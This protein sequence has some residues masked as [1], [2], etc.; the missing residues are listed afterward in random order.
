MNK[1]FIRHKLSVGDIT[2]LS[3]QDSERIISA[4]ELREGDFVLL[5][6]LEGV[7]KGQIAYIDTASVEVEVFSESDREPES[8]GIEGQSLSIIQSVIPDGK[9]E[10]FIE[11]AVELGVNEIIPA[12][13]EYSLMSW[14]KARSKHNEWVAILKKAV[15]Q[16]RSKESPI[17]QHTNK[18]ETLEFNEL[19]EGELRLCLATENVRAM[20]L[21][22]VLKNNEFTKLIVAVGPEKGWHSEELE[23]F[24]QN[25]FQFVTLGERILR[26]ETVGLA[27]ASVYQFIKGEF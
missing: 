12:H 25:G 13:T 23:F 17:I 6:T 4:G 10:F 21:S 19:A 3:D 9:F 5:D 18:L 1:Y 14:R 26:T 8:T 24:K 7:F 16:S 22:R 27:I 2:N 11:K 15:E 20:K